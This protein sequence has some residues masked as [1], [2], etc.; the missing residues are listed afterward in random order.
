[1]F[2]NRSRPFFEQCTREAFEAARQNQFS[3]SIVRR[4]VVVL[5]KSL[6]VAVAS[7]HPSGY[8]SAPWSIPVRSFHFQAFPYIGRPTSF[9]QPKVCLPPS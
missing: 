2:Q 1:M 3:V 7:G 5:Y 9:N 4:T 6:L 8:A